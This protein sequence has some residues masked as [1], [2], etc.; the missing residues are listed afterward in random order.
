MDGS[1]DLH[2]DECWFLCG[3]RG[4]PAGPRLVALCEEIQRDQQTLIANTNMC[5]SVFQYGGGA[6]NIDP[7]EH[8]SI[9]D[10]TLTYNAAQNA[11]ETVFAKIVKNKIALMP[12]TAGGGP[13]A[14]HR[15]KEMEKAIEGVFADNNGEELEENVIL[16]SLVTDHGAGACIVEDGRDR[17][18][19][20]HVAVED[21]WFDKAETRMGRPS[22]CF[23]VPKDGI[24]KFSAI[25]ILANPADDDEKGRPGFVGTAAERREKIIKAA[26]KPSSW[27]TASAGS[28]RVDIY[29]AWHPPT[30]REECEEDEEYEDEETG[31]RRTRKRTVVK[32]DGRHVIAVHGED[33][34]LLDEP[35]DEP[36]WPILLCVPRR[37]RRHVFG[38]SLMRGL[39]APQREYER[40]TT[41]IQFMHQKM[42]LSG[43]M[44]PNTANINV[45]EITAGQKGAGFFVGYDTA[46]GAPPIQQ[47][48]PQPVE[49]STYAYVDSIP[50][51]MLE[52]HGISTLAAASQLPAGLQ[53]AS[54]KALQVFEDFED[55]RLLPYHR[56][57]ER[58]RVALA[59]LII[60]S[61][62]R[63]VERTGGYKVSYR[64][65]KGLEPV[66]WKDL[67]DLI[68]DK[69]SFVLTVFPVSAL[70]KNPAAKFAQLTEMLNAGAINIEQFKRLF[71]LP[72]LEAENELDTADT[73]ILDRN[74]DIMVTTGRYIGP[75]GF[76]NLDLLISRAGKYI[77][78]LRQKDVPDGRIK[79][80][81]D[82]IEDAKGLKESIGMPPE[83]PLPG[84]PPAPPGPPMGMAA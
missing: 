24:D 16:D 1:V 50:R 73:D 80:I 57:R 37:R 49:P 39:L 41:K 69:D 17:T 60:K 43:F 79:L 81:R 19:I 14:R 62:R 77:N 46:E 11:V 7:E 84:M 45:R 2:D 74:M 68:K 51:N 13:L 53:Q 29:E 48:Q 3:A 10:E 33:G 75:E 23:Y 25:E 40:G 71:E 38:L 65:K 76:D 4:K 18:Y 36:E 66:D 31:E 78:L 44:G 28:Y 47:L 82:Y 9:D 26:S 27:R 63:I 55:V 54:G 35:W 61:A 8:V 34:T 32:H 70:S 20:R 56:A 64:G 30:M 58:F 22:C 67:M 5:M 52:R 72:D 59:W 21:V 6:R 12:L 42:G 83:G 15:A